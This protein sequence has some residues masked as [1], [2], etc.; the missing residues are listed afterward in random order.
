MERRIKKDAPPNGVVC[1]TNKAVIKEESD[2]VAANVQQKEGIE[3]SFS[4]VVALNRSSS[5]PVQPFWFIGF[6]SSPQSEMCTTIGYE[7]PI[8]PPAERITVYK[9]CSSTCT[10][11]PV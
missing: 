1:K 10:D 9:T 2:T 5:T 8:L 11:I 3:A 4:E 7:K 6:P